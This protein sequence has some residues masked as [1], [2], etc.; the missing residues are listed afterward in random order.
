M[1]KR[2]ILL[3]IFVTLLVGLLG[4]QNVLELRAEEPRRA[5]TS[6][7]MLLSGDYTHL[8]INGEPYYNKPPLFN[9]VLA[10]FYKI[11]NSF[12]EWVV[13]LP[14]LLSFILTAVIVYITGKRY[15]GK[16]TALLSALFYLTAGD[17]LLY[18]AVNSGE[19]DLFYTLITILQ[20]FCIFHYQQKGNYFLLFITSYLFTTLGVLTKGLPSLP[21]QAF[22]I[23]GWLIYTGNWKKMFSWQHALGIL[24]LIS[25]VAGYF[26][27]YNNSGDAQAYILNLLNE[28]ADKSSKEW[29]FAKLIGHVFTFPLNFIKLILPWGLLLPFTFTKKFKSTIKAHPLLAFSLVFIVANIWIYWISPGTANRYL[30][31]FFPFAFY[32]IAQF[33]TLYANERPKT[34]LIIERVFLG[35]ISITLLAFVALPFIKATSGLQHI[36]IIAALL[37]IGT[38]LLLYYYVKLNTHRLLI[39]VLFMAVLRIGFNLIAAPLTQ[40]DSKSLVYRDAINRVLAITKDEPVYYYGQPYTYHVK[41]KLPGLNLGETDIT[42]PP[43]VPF[44]IP[45]YISRGNKHICQFTNKLEKGKF[46][47]SREIWLPKNTLVSILS[48]FTETTHQEKIVLFTVD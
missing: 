9:I 26:T 47:I 42:I 20:V 30:Y 37:I 23:V 31:V 46:Y 33:Y 6:I 7:E 24:L 29:S 15:L 2:N 34:K 22:T 4:W 13:R 11:F 45:Y 41:N 32:I 35:L 3:L 43:L 1:A 38:A 8:Q 25:I 14:S 39:M 5:I 27:L 40:A 12:S 21:F 44:Q 36:H 18:G 19:I 48:S 10:F 16:Q 17:L 28:G